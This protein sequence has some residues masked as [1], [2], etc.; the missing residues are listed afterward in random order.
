MSKGGTTERKERIIF[1]P[2]LL[3]WEDENSKGYI[4]YY[5]FFLWRLDRV[6]LADDLIGADQ[7]IP[8]WLI[9]ILFLVLSIESKLEIL[10]FSTSDAIL[11]L[12]FSL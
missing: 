6:H 1:R 7:K 8:D 11:G 10:G 12:W 9:K 2:A 5:L 3:Y 4:M